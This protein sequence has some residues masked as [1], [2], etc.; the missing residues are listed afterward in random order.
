MCDYPLYLYCFCLNPFGCLKH[1]QGV[2]L[3]WFGILAAITLI[4]VEWRTPMLKIFRD[5][6][7]ALG[8]LGVACLWTAGLLA[9]RL[10]GINKLAKGIDEVTSKVLESEAMVDKTLNALR[11]SNLSLKDGL[12]DLQE[13]NIKMR[14]VGRRLKVRNNQAK[15]Q[16]NE[17]HE[18]IVRNSVKGSD[19][20]SQRIAIDNLI[21]EQ[22]ETLG[23]MQYSLEVREDDLWGKFDKK[24]AQ[25]KKGIELLSATAGEINK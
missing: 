7:H 3:N 16:E 19:V 22:Y 23:W 9:N 12:I 20:K 5:Y 1:I 21:R 14:R 11:H 2:I 24:A 15:Q 10:W 6:D 4:A 18:L 25:Y 17:I 13:K 8:F